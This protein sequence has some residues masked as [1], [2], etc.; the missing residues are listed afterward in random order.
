MPVPVFVVDSF[1]PEPW[2]GN[3]AGVCLLDVPRD[4]AW[5]QSVAAELKHAET[6]F[7]RPAGDG[8]DLRW[9]TPEAEVDL[10]GHATLAAAHVLWAAGRLPAHAPARFSTR[11]GALTAR[12][13]GDGLIAMDFPA[14]PASPV[15]APPALAAALG[16]P[17][18]GPAPEVLVFAEG[19]LVP[20]DDEAAVAALEPDFAALAALSVPGHGVPVIVVV[21]APAER[22]GVDF[23]SRVFA[24]AVGIPE[25]PVTGAAHCGLGPFWA[26]RLGRDALTGRQISA[27]GGT[28][29]VRVLGDRVELR[30]EAVLVLRGEL[31]V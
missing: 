30:G 22:D 18:A 2:R 11:S 6:A 27:R 8:Y 4:D 24:P 13:A 21:T 7:V 12:L 23:V 19:L 10:C 25:D 14:L 9:F 3:P 17:A 5:M 16:L 28:V 26:E 15:D 1:T 29:R 20:L 31:L